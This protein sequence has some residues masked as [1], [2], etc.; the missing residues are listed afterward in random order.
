MHVQVWYE[1]SMAVRHARVG[2]F[3]TLLVKKKYPPEECTY[4]CTS[5]ARAGTKKKYQ[6]TLD[7]EQTGVLSSGRTRTCTYAPGGRALLAATTWKVLIGRLDHIF[8][9]NFFVKYT[10]YGN[11]EQQ[12]KARGLLQLRVVSMKKCEPA[13]LGAMQLQ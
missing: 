6:N 13:T 1:E 7:M 3:G 11:V 12:S 10:I 5:H 2:Y 4:V 8:V 9:Q